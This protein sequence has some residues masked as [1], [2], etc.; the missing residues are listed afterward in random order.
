MTTSIVPPST[1][2]SRGCPVR[3]QPKLM[4]VPDTVSPGAGVSIA[5]NGSTDEPLSAVKVLVPSSVVWPST[6]SA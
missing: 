5:P 6:S 4:R 1:G 2:I 3:A